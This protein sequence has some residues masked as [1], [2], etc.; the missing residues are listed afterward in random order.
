MKAIEVTLLRGLGRER[1]HWG[2]FARLL[3]SELHNAI[4][5]YIDLPGTGELHQSPSPWSIQ[6]LAATL[7]SP[8]V[9]SGT[10]RV[11]VAISLGAMVGF[12]HLLR[13]EGRAFDA[14]V[15]INTSF[16][17]WNPMWQR[18]RPT[19]WWQL[20]RV[21][22]SC[23]VEQRE[24]RILQL[25]SAR[26]ERI[27]QHLPGFVQI[28]QSAPVSLWTLL[29]QMLAAARYRP[30]LPVGVDFPPILILNSRGDQLVSSCASQTIAARLGATLHTHPHAGHDLPLDEP[31]WTCAQVVDF[32]RCIRDE[33][34]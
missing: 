21:A 11:L 5:S 26:V 20:L 2:D 13:S 28:Q 15:L 29:A 31:H 8:E 4:F 34:A 30:L 7:P 19:A 27:E 6:A 17:G 23:T 10:L 22:C 3:E 9:K 25:V 14:V 32:V 33:P 18:A 12:E 16:G 24:Q 1:R